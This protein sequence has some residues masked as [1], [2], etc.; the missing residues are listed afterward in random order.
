MTSKKPDSPVKPP[1]IDLEAEDIVLDGPSAP[2]PPPPPKKSK[3]SAPWFIAA[4]LT[5]TVAGGWFYKEVL[6]S[7]LPGNELTVAKGSIET[8]QAQNKTLSEQVAA[9]SAASDQLKTQLASM[10]S[11]IQSVAGKSATAASGLDARIGAAEKAAASTRADIEKLK[12]MP[13]GGTSVSGTDNAA[14]ASLAQRLDAVEKDVASLKTVSKPSDQSALANSLSLSMSDLKAKI[15]NGASYR[16]EFDRVSR[17]VPAAA[18]LD[19]LAAHADEGLPTA[20]G[21]AKELTGLI[22]LL[23]KPE[24]DVAAPDGSY[25]DGFWNMMNG[26]ITIRKIGEAD[27]PNV[28][29]QCAALA[30]SG[31]LAQAVEK[32]DKAEGTKPVALSNWRDRAAARITLEGKLEETSLAVARQVGSLGAAP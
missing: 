25:M 22:P 23:P 12:L 27:W 19:T 20:S 32:I 11:E 1:I 4:V 28:A 21:L 10:S 6:S 26:L 18:G 7:Y 3:S 2:S 24:A 15:A 16:S 30:E 17:M 9:I 29:T 8:L 5:G 14:L 31:D 13:T